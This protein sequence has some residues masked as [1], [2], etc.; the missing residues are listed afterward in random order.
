MTK[1]SLVGQGRSWV[2]DLNKRISCLLSFYFYEGSWYRI[3]CNFTQAVSLV[4]PEVPSWVSFVLVGLAVAVW[5]QQLCLWLSCC[6]F[7]FFFFF[8]CG[9]WRPRHCK[10]LTRLSRASKVLRK[11]MR[12]TSEVVRGFMVAYCAWF[13]S[14]GYLG[15]PVPCR[16]TQGWISQQSTRAWATSSWLPQ[17]EG[18]TSSGSAGYSLSTK[19]CQLALS[20]RP[21]LQLAKRRVLCLQPGGCLLPATICLACTKQ[22]LSWRPW[23]AGCWPEPLWQ[24]SP[25]IQLSWSREITP[26]QPSASMGWKIYGPWGKVRSNRWSLVCD[27]SWP[28]SGSRRSCACYP[29]TCGLPCVQNRVR[30]NTVALSCH[31]IKMYGPGQKAWWFKIIKSA[32]K[33]CFSARTPVISQVST[34]SIPRFSC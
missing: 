12:S 15:T 22:M 29:C 19:Y 32:M 8:F 9:P 34:K 30:K 3:P 31:G 4:T 2:T 14:A 28:W 33:W 20:H 10:V 1:Y 13:T 25:A 17:N 7:F 16:E 11:D 23:G 6:C 21:G 5:K 27:D 24:P 26:C 18:N